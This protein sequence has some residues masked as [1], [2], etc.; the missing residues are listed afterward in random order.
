MFRLEHS[1]HRPRAYLTWRNISMDFESGLIAA[2]G[3][4]FPDVPVPDPPLPPPAEGDPPHPYNV[5]LR[6]CAFHFCQ[7]VYKH[8][9]NVNGLTVA[10]RNADGLLARFL[11]RIFALIFLPEDRVA[12]C[13]QLLRDQHVPPLYAGPQLDAFLQYFYTQWV[14]NN[15]MRLM[16][17]VYDRVEGRRTNNEVEG[18]HF[19]LTTVF[20][21][22]GNLWSF[23]QRLRELQNTSMLLEQAIMNATAYMPPRKKTYRVQE[24]AL[25]T[26]RNSFVAGNMYAS[27]F[28]YVCA[29]A[30][31]MHDF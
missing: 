31:H 19:Y 21:T 9:V 8:L 16:A 12:A 24:K 15:R 6:G 11:R 5:V 14:A 26:M 7:A 13:F 22:H 28:E 18:F 30:H 29:V 27:D 4:V 17:N 2:L 25:A 1:F 20:E 23:T 3:T 10:Y